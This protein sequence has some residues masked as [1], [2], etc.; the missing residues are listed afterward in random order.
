MGP[1]DMRLAIAYAL[2]H[3][4]RWE[5]TEVAKTDPQFFAFKESAVPGSLTF[6]KPDRLV[7][8]ALALAEAAGRRGGTA[9]AI[10]N[11]ANEIAVAAFLADRISFL[12]IANL[13]EATLE[14]LPAGDLTSLEEAASAD[15]EA[16]RLATELLSRRQF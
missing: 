4:D 1:T 16:R 9:P 15:R 10:L 2:S 6:E 11:A 12:G 3:P 8:K 5:L 7:F 13:V 14:A